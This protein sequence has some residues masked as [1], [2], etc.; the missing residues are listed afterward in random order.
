MMPSLQSSPL[1]QQ[2]G[3]R[4][5][6]IDAA[7]P[8]I[9]NEELAGTKVHDQNGFCS[10]SNHLRDL[11]DPSPGRDPEFGQVS[12]DRMQEHGA[13]FDQESPGAVQHRGR[14][15]LGRFDRHEAHGRAR[16]GLADCF[17][18]RGIVLL[19][20]HVRFH[21]GR[22]HE[23]DLMAESSELAGPVVGGRARLHTDQAGRQACTELDELRPPDL[24]ADGNPPLG[25]NG[26][27]L[28]HRLGEV[29]ADCCDLSHVFA[30]SRPPQTGS[31]WHRR[32]REPSTPSSMGTCVDAPGNARRIFRFDTAR[33]SDADMC[34]A[35]SAADHTPRARMGVRGSGPNQFYALEALVPKL[36][37]LIP[38]Q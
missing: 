13:L 25:I 10:S 23:P 4:S 18:I 21:I 26:M 32:E 27:D 9:V 7:I 1:H 15:L 37:C 20:L 36:V 28:E 34:A 12:T 31:S 11:R 5:G 38:S 33:R 8:V 22:R 3:E 6:G 16:H 24:S 17:R 29:Q 30:P 35:S 14:L 19:P 2:Q